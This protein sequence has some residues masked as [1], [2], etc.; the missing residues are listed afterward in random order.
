VQCA[1]IKVKQNNTLG[2]RSALIEKEI[3]FVL[4]SRNRSAAGAV[5]FDKGFV[6]GR[7]SDSAC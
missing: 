1:S 5:F 7:E 6:A 4:L 3:D 2:R